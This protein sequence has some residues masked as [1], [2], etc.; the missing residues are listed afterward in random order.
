MDVR[1]VSSPSRR[2]ILSEVFL[3]LFFLFQPGGCRGRPKEE[4]EKGRGSFFFF[5]FFLRP[6]TVFFFFPSPPLFLFPSFLAL[7]GWLPNHNENEKGYGTLRRIH[8]HQLIER[9]FPLFFFSP[10]LFSFLS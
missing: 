10:F 7:D 3:S 8:G 1:P 6:V 5:L 4:E 2:Y 9:F